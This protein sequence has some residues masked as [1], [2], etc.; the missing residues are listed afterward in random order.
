MRYRDETERKGRRIASTFVCE[1]ELLTQVDRQYDPLGL[2]MVRDMV[3]EQ[4]QARATTV[5]RE[6]V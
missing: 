3:E 6:N 4:A 2:G 5:K 1:V